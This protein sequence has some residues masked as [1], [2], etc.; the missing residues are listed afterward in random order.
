MP[1]LL[2]NANL[3]PLTNVTR[4][5]VVSLVEL[6]LSEE[7]RETLIV[8]R[9]AARASAKTSKSSRSARLTKTRS[10]STSAKGVAAAPIQKQ[11]QDRKAKKK[12]EDEKKKLQEYQ[13]QQ[14]KKKESSTG[15][16]TLDAQRDANKA[17]QDARENSLVINEKLRPVIFGL[18][19]FLPTFDATGEKPTPIGNVIKINRAIKVLNAENLPADI[20]I[21]DQGA[22]EL[23]YLEAYAQYINQVSAFLNS[24]DA[25]NF[26]FLDDM[27]SFL[28]LSA[29]SSASCSNTQLLVAIL[30]DYATAVENC[31]PRLFESEER[32]F[33]DEGTRLPENPTGITSLRA[34]LANS[35]AFDYI[36]AVLG[37]DQERALKVLLYQI[38][39]ELKMSYNCSK[40]GTNYNAGTLLQTRSTS[41]SII[42]GKSSEVS[43]LGINQFIKS[44]DDSGGYSFLFPFEKRDILPDDSGLI[45]DSAPDVVAKE[46]SGTSSIN[47]YSTIASTTKT[48]CSSLAALLD[49]DDLSSSYAPSVAGFI[50]A[51]EKITIPLLDAL[52]QDKPAR[53][54]VVEFLFLSLAATD[55]E[56]LAQLMLF[57][58]ALKEELSRPA[59]ESNLS[60]AGRA[61]VI[62]SL[63]STPTLGGGVASFDF[64]TSELSAAAFPVTSAP[65]TK[66]S[67]FG[68]TS[69][70]GAVGLSAPSV[71]TRSSSSRIA[72]PVAS[73]PGAELA[74]AVVDSAIVKSTAAKAEGLV[75]IKVDLAVPLQPQTTTS[76]Y[77]TEYVDICDATAALL[78][79]ALSG[80]K[81]TGKP[82]G[83]L[84]TLSE[85]AI[86]SALRSISTS[87]VDS[88][89]FIT[90]LTI[91]D[92]FIEMFSSSSGSCFSGSNTVYSGMSRGNIEIAFFMCI[93]KIQY[94][95]AFKSYEITT[96]N[97][98]QAGADISLSLERLIDT[99][100]YLLDSFSGDIDLDELASASSSLA[101]I[102]ESLIDEEADVATFPA[103]FSEYMDSTSMSFT[104]LQAALA[105]DTDDTSATLTLQE[106]IATGLPVAS[107]LA[108][109]LS[110]FIDFYNSDA[111][112]F[113]G[114]KA[115]DWA[116][117]DISLAFLSS[118]LQGTD[119]SENKKVLAVGIP[120]G[121]CDAIYNVPVSLEDSTRDISELAT[122][123]FEVEI[124]KIDLTRSSLKFKPKIFSF[125]RNIK[126]NSFYQEDES[127][128]GVNYSVFDSTLAG[129][130]YTESGLTE[131][132]TSDSLQEQVTNLKNDQALKMYMSLLYDLNFS[133]FDHPIEPVAKESIF[134]KSVTLSAADKVD[135]GSDGFLSGSNLA[136]DPLHRAMSSFSWYDES[137]N[138]LKLDV[139]FEGD[140]SAFS[141]WEYLSSIGA[142]AQTAFAEEQLNLGCKFE[143][144]VLVPF[145]PYDFDV[146]TDTFGD[147]AAEDNRINDALTMAEQ[148]IGM[149]L[150]TS[151]GV[152]LATFRV[153]IRIPTLTE[154]TKDE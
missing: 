139:D 18:L 69:K 115:T 74:A 32:D 127:S 151:Q 152:E 75:A 81:T 8:Q 100:E 142:V 29:E 76:S 90:L 133:I 148:E 30:R 109:Q 80:V 2:E 56:M 102:L 36:T 130:T 40:Y 147:E 134:S 59:L 28:A 114:F 21:S 103:T 61:K 94:F 87:S 154:D 119:F 131:L 82:S 43:S 145:D 16:T 10:A 92:D 57:L 138:K 31:S 42:P 110:A 112:S 111:A 3:E 132:N 84:I 13:T 124:E 23:D 46:Q 106:R 98:D 49:T 68:P 95:A 123:I 91:F 97:T 99:S 118:I 107:D 78:L 48:A 62:G 47:V 86:A 41:T 85:S 4:K 37:E 11:E 105:S 26:S 96:N 71:N 77:S 12:Q 15:S 25:G 120:A 93:C 129:S 113:T 149:G 140:P 70:I 153:T 83:T 137:T 58:A 34:V 67:S 126:I 55:Q 33:P 64:Q 117:N 39:A 14:G 20:D 79:K 22:L 101:R 24:L 125:S 65:T 45:F 128:I 146:E 7:Q 141:V 1:N 116:V 108:I 122:D 54:D 150:E 88:D 50:L 73:N 51:I 27:L 35:N 19:D 17:L 6:L 143:N 144:V 38:S 66:V 135:T 104:A 136:F 89:V 53:R 52:T 44:P 60:V 121:L 5:E 72:V 9:E 63:A